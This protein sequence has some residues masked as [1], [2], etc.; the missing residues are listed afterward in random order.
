MVQSYWNSQAIKQVD[1][2]KPENLE[3]YECN[4]SSK[5]DTKILNVTQIWIH[6]THIITF[7]K[8]LYEGFESIVAQ[9]TS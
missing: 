2:M 3:L 4:S 9:D 5:R 7:S 8:H 1:N 6:K